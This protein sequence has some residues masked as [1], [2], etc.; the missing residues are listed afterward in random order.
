MSVSVAKAQNDT[1]YFLPN[2]DIE[3]TKELNESGV[4]VVKVDDKV[5]RLKAL[6]TL[7]EVLSENT[8]VFVKTYGRGSLSTASFRGTTASHTKV[9]W[10][11]ISL[12]SSMMGMVDMSLVP[13][14]VADDV[15]IL[16]GSA[17][18]QKGE[19]AIGGLVEISTKPEWKK[20]VS[21][22]ITSSAG[23]FRTFDNL[24]AIRVGDSIIQSVTKFYINSSKNDFPFYN[25]DIASDSLIK[26]VREN[27]DYKKKGFIEELY[28]HTSAKSYLSLKFW[29]QDYD[30]GVPGLTTN[31]SGISGNRNRQD[32][33]MFISSLEY[34]FYTDKSKLEVSVGSNLQSQNYISQAYIGGVGYYNLVDS[35]SRNASIYSS[36]KYSYSFFENLELSALVKY[37][38]HNVKSLDDILQNG[39]NSKRDDYGLLVSLFYEPVNRLKF[40][41]SL[42]QDF[43]DRNVCPF[44]PSVYAE[45]GFAHRWNIRASFARNYSV[46]T[47]NDLYY[48]PGGN[49]DLSPES[50]FVVDFGIGKKLCTANQKFTLSAEAEANYGNYSNWIMWRPSNLGYWKPENIEK[51]VTYGADFSA[52]M[53]Y[54]FSDTCGISLSANYAYTHSSNESSVNNV[55]DRSIGKQLPYIPLHSANIFGKVSV[56]GFYFFYQWNYFSE[57]YTTSAEETGVLVS[58]YPYFMSDIGVGKELAV[59][60]FYFDFCFKIYNLFNESYRSVL[61]QP[62]PGINFAFQLNI[63]FR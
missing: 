54:D 40:G 2:V 34:K 59:K 37:N 17:T 31:E 21:A 6:N 50:G 43:Y 23:S 24:A 27:A 46:P 15:N 42:R 41:I 56:Y 38:H 48:V 57:R 32:G 14:S 28:F 29:Y 10:N 8:S 35:D 5:L 33:R 58:I 30:R 49:P 47:L 1:V 44:A 60:D 12:G 55:N 4:K 61:W 39:Y 63:K 20:G 25:S 51:V 62:M 22:R 16:C 7:S 19:N 45:Y 36:A 11:N 3:D 26:Q 13:M 18:M 52:K 9:T 53:S